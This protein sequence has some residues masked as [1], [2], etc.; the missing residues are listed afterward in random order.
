M[1]H[2]TERQRAWHALNKR[3]KRIP[4][5]FE[6]DAEIERRRTIEEQTGEQTGNNPSIPSVH[7]PAPS[8]GGDYTK[9]TDGGIAGGTDRGTIGERRGNNTTVPLGG[10]P[11]VL[12]SECARR[13]AHAHSGR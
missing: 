11:V 6:V 10:V 4:G 2:R 8:R 5:P 12:C 1:A 13:V 3:L 7:Q 9:G